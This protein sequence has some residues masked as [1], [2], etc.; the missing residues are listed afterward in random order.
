V[1]FGL[2]RLDHAA[3]ALLAMLMQRS[4][5]IFG[6]RV[7]L[8]R[9]CTTNSRPSSSRRTCCRDKTTSWSEVPL[10]G[11]TVMSECTNQLFPAIE[12]GLMSSKEDIN[13]KE[14]R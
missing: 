14:G 11:Y 12:L 5:V 10:C 2:F 7:P 3:A 4:Q 9:R 1:A 6:A 13:P 8:K